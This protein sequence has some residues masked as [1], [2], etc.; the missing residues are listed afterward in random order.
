MAAAGLLLE[1]SCHLFYVHAMAVTGVWLEMH[2]LAGFAIEGSGV[3][4]MAALSLGFVLLKVPTRLHNPQ[5]I[6]SPYLGGGGGGGGGAQGGCT[7]TK[8]NEPQ[9][10]ATA[11]A[12]HS[13][14]PESGS[15]HRQLQLL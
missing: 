12:L 11:V 4:S 13:H 1:L 10:L 7:A 15:N 6:S 3:L 9:V 2:Q 8:R 5:L 14:S